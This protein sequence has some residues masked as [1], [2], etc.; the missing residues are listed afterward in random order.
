M[1]PI[2]KQHV[3]DCI[4]M[5]IILLEKTTFTQTR[6][7][8]CALRLVSTIDHEVRP[9]KMAFFNGPTR[10]SNFHGLISQKINL[11]SL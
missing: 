10:W 3:Y 7:H 5:R 8:V 2:N 6:F 11:Q 4:S 9:W 1:R